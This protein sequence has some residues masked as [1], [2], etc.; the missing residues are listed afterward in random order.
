MEL[1]KFFGAVSSDWVRYSQYELRKDE[2]GIV[3]VTP[4]P[5][6]TFKVYNP[7][8]VSSK[9]VVDALGIGSL[10]VSSSPNHKKIERAVLRFAK[11]YGLLGFMPYLPFNRNY[12]QRENVY[13][14]K[15]D[16]TGC[17]QMKT[18]DYMDLFLPFKK[19][20]VMLDSILPLRPAELTGRPISYDVVFS[21]AYS[22]RLDWLSSYFEAFFTHF[23]ATFYHK[24]TS[25][26]RFRGWFEDEIEHF[27]ND[28][29]GYSIALRDGKPTL[30]W[31]FNSLKLAMETIYSFYITGESCP[32]RICRDCGKVFYAASARSEFCETKCRNRHNVEQYR[33]RAKGQPEGSNEQ[34]MMEAIVREI[35]GQYVLTRVE[36]RETNVE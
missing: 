26:D 7:L 3:Y 20:P 22:E 5:E 30:L 24:K 17:E 15:T 33:K 35:R 2:N 31:S 25:S 19:E 21:N 32:L 36:P 28:G 14:P 34:E 23:A 27:G 10:M 12:F 1:S 16:I 29:L 11:N 6:V 4:A 8:D 13:L 9:L 18:T